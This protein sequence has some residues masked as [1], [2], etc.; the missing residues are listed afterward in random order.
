ML[1]TFIIIQ[2]LEQFDMHNL[3]HDVRNLIL[4][5]VVS[6]VQLSNS[7]LL[8]KITKPHFNVFASSMCYRVFLQIDNRRVMDLH[9]YCSMILPYNFF[10]QIQYPCFL[11]CTERGASM[12]SA[13]H[14]N[15]ATTGSFL[16]LQ[17]TGAPPSINTYQLY[18][19]YPQHLIH[20]RIRVK[21]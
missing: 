13:S 1:S 6:Q 14:D 16:E 5:F 15:N 8:S 12:Y 4:N 9:G 17:E 10:N 11:T 19:F 7:Y 3:C 21:K 18:I 2:S 20:C